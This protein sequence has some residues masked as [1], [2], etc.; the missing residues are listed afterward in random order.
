VSSSSEG[1]HFQ[2]LDHL[3]A[4]AAF[5]VVFWHFAH[6]PDNTPVPLAESP[7][8]GIL[9]EGHSGVA[10]FMV[11]SGY[12]FAR[13]LG[14]RTIDFRQFAINRLLRLLPLLLLVF[15]L[16]GLLERR[17]DP[18]AYSG[19]LL[20]G[21]IYG[22][23]LGAW[24][25]AVEIHFYL[26]LPFILFW[27]RRHPWLPLL[28]IAGMIALRSQLYLHGAELQPLAFHS[29]IGRA[30]Q[31]LLGIMAARYTPGRRLSL[32]VFAIFYLY[33]AGFTMAGGGYGLL[34][35]PIWIIHPTIEAVGFAGLIRWYDSKPWTGPVMDF[36]AKG[37][38]YSYGIY[39]L[40][41]FNVTGTA[42]ALDGWIGFDTIFEALPFA[43]LYFIAMGA[44]AS[45]VYRCVEAPFLRYRRPYT[46][47][48]EETN[49]PGCEPTVQPGASP[50]LKPHL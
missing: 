20:F 33:Y 13:L 4:L 25:I 32:A 3:R 27:E 26:L 18:L 50:V 40:H 49:E 1:K 29:L 43:L 19:E 42:A 23:P 16:H 14:D 12:L 24:S 31:F 45:A 39:L 38:K 8:F 35:S 48:A 47:A 2:S 5:L 36:V 15:L 10:L 41:S 9:D 6:R 46:R 28:A 17:D 11:L 21:L 34:K 44:V 7:A 22:W 30:D 37:G